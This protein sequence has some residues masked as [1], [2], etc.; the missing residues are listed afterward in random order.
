[1]KNGNRNKYRKN[2]NKNRWKMITEISAKNRCRKSITRV[3]L[4]CQPF[5]CIYCLHTSG[6]PWGQTRPINNFHFSSLVFFHS[7]SPP[8][9]YPT[10][11][12][13]SFFSSSSW[14]IFHVPRSRWVKGAYPQCLGA[15]ER[16]QEV[17]PRC[18]RLLFDTRGDALGNEIKW[19]K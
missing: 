8:T 1:M 9:P 7:V 19:N 13:F 2:L 11:F 17:A 16:G 14:C 5:S 12:S 4:L 3:K 15:Q 6:Q 10:S 18:P